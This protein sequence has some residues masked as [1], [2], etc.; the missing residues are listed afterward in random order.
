[1]KI[2]K[3][4]LFTCLCF[5]AV[6]SFAQK[7]AEKP[8]N[9]WSRD[10]SLKILSDSSWARTYQSTQASAAADAAAAVRHQAGTRLSGGD[11]GS[12]ALIGA[13]APVV[14]RLHS[15]LPIRQALTRLNQLS[16]GYDKMD[17]KG[18]AE[19]DVSV[20]KFLE[21]AICQNYY[22]V[23]LTQFPN[24]T[25]QSVE[26]AIFQGMKLE[27][28]KGNVWLTNEKGEKRELIQ[29]TPPKQRGD[30][31]VFFFARKDDKG[32]EF[33]TTANKELNFEFN[34]NFL[35]SSNRFARFVPRRF[36]FKISK[37]TVGENLMF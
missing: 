16:A 8:S 2:N 21:C 22:V 33:L 7:T 19:F 32:V 26:E 24:T 4:F 23:T 1:M 5:M 34:N 18:K 15:A 29:F 3:L 35:T 30:S 12:S 9:K 13:P 37:M 10:E 28:M 25:G 36:E 27:H 20:K 11:P 17:E 14:I 31:A 6:S